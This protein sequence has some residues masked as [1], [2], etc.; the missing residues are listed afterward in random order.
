MLHI[1]LRLLTDNFLR[2]ITNNSS[3]LNSVDFNTFF[4]PN[5][6]LHPSSSSKIYKGN[7]I[8]NY[9]NKFSDNPKLK[10]VNSQYHFDQINRHMYMNSSNLTWFVGE[11]PPNTY[12]KSRINILYESE[13]TISDYKIISIISS[14]L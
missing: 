14:K 1:K 4:H 11:G 12:L 7:Q 5:A 2:C 10:L 8:I 3:K 9:I 6:V 13:N